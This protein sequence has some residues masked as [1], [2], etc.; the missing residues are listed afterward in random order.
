MSEEVEDTCPG[1]KGSKRD[2]GNDERC[3]LQRVSVLSFFGCVCY[4]CHRLEE[5]VCFLFEPSVFCLSEELSH[6]LN[7]FILLQQLCGQSVA[8][9]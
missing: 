6:A 9:L 2:I 8:I 1:L 7:V 4:I 3:T 5:L